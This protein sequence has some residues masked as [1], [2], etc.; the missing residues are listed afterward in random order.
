[1]IGGFS[2]HTITYL[3]APACDAAK[4]RE[5][6]KKLLDRNSKSIYLSNQYNTKVRY[7]NALSIFC[8]KLKFRDC[9]V[10]WKFTHETSLLADH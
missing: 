10:F 2:C 1:M 7:I 5:V 4:L 9:Q 8:Y 6:K 3:Q